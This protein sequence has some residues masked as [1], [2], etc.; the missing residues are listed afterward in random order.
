[1]SFTRM[2]GPTLVCTLFYH[3]C[4]SL[5]FMQ[6]T[7]HRMLTSC[8]LHSSSKVPPPFPLPSPPPSALSRLCQHP[9]PS[10]AGDVVGAAAYLVEVL[11][12]LEG[13]KEVR[14]SLLFRHH[15]VQADPHTSHT[16]RQEQFDWM[17][18]QLP[19][20]LAK[21]PQPYEVAMPSLLQSPPPPPPPP[22]PLFS[23]LPAH[24]HLT[25]P[26]SSHC[27]WSKRSRGWCTRWISPSS[28][29]W[30]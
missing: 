29:P 20:L 15:H 14:C 16:H 18:T 5:T 8:S 27:C 25:S 19:F 10:L 9:T 28:L 11:R 6:V 4:V 2:E 7:P 1:L 26:P 23:L 21:A 13:S 30:P 3:C 12:F 24:A 22:P 17:G